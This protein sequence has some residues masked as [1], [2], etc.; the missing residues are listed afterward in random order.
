[1]S[2]RSAV[3]RRTSEGELNPRQPCPCGS[4]KRYKACHGGKGG[5]AD[6]VVTRPFEGLAAECELIALRECVP[7]AT[8]TLPVEGSRQIVLGTVLPMV[9]AAL[10]R[11]EEQALVGVQVHTRSNDISRDLGRALRWALTAEPGGVLSGL[12]PGHVDDDAA[13]DRL[14]DLLPADAELR[15]EVHSDFGWWIPEGAEATGDVALAMERANAAVMSTQ[16]LD[17]EGLRAVYWVD[18]GDKGHLR[19]VRPEP[20]ERLLAAMARLSVRGELDL[21][22]GSRYAGSFRAHG[23]LVPVWDLDPEPHAREWEKPAVEFDSRLADALASLETEPL[24]ESER[25]ALHGLHGR[26]VTLR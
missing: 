6:V 1:M 25:R 3:K 15:P 14:Q 24:I 7:S 4:G 20:E 11:T 22:E 10:V 19:W 17:A 13:G 2:K 21:G 5:P 16:R 9:A 12:S 23:L 26:Q 18:A 8:V